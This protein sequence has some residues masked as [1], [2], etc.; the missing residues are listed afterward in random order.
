MALGLGLPFGALAALGCGTTLAVTMW[1][2]IVRVHA[3]VRAVVSQVASEYGLKPL[4]INMENGQL[5]HTVSEVH[6]KTNS[7]TKRKSH[8]EP[9]KTVR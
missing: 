8:V 9:D 1:H 4:S 6:E 7:D 3:G 5:L 2:R